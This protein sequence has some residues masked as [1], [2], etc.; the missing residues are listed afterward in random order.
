MSPL[1][2]VLA[3]ALAACVLLV[4]SPAGNFGFLNYDDNQYLQDVPEVAAGLSPSSIAWA[5]SHSHVGQWHPLTTLSWMMDVSLFGLDGGGGFHMHNVILHVAA[6]VLLFLAMRSL[7]GAVWRSA[8]VAALFGLHPLRV[9]SV[10]WIVERKDVLS[11]AFMMGTIWAY[12]AYAKRPFSWGRLSIVC[13]IFALGLLSKP[14]LVTLPVVFLLLDV[15]PLGRIQWNAAADGGA[16]KNFIQQALPLFKEKTPLFVLSLAAS[17]ITILGQ[18]AHFN[19]ITPL[20]VAQRLSYIP[21]SYVN[22]LIELVWPFNLSAHYP[23]SQDG[24]TLWAFVASLLFLIAATV[25]LFKLRKNYLCLLIGWLWFV[26]TLLPV[27]GIFYNGIQIRA[28]RYT[29]ISQIGLIIA[30][31]WMVWDLVGRNKN[32]KIA[33]SIAAPVL[34]MVL[35]FSSSRQVR[36]WESDLALWEHCVANTKDN[37]YAQSKLGKSLQDLKDY[38]GSEEHYRAALKLNPNGIEA[39]NNLASILSMKGEMQEALELQRRTVVVFPKW[40]LM[41]HNLGQHLAKNGDYAGAKNSYLRALELEP[42]SFATS[43]QLASML[44][45][46]FGDKASLEEAADILNRAITYQPLQAELYY[47]LGNI[48][49]RQAR[50]DD[51]IAS[52]RKTLEID[53]K[54]SGAANNLGALLVAKGLDDEAMELFT[55]AIQDNATNLDAYD[56]LAQTMIKK[57]KPEEAVN[58]LRSALKLAP[59]HPGCHIRLAW[60][61]ATSPVDSIRNGLEATQMANRAGELAGKNFPDVLDSLAAAYAE[62]GRFTEA[63]EAATKALEHP[64]MQNN[65]ERASQIRKHLEMYRSGRPFRDVAA[66]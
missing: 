38:A 64:A 15:W 14:M 48:R 39:L 27:I 66:P 61:L 51:A 10:A 43:Y 29:Y 16:M 57:G 40:H 63:Q 3:V 5:F 54:H 13:V 53:P 6:T 8:L 9:E 36:V 25:F 22:Y 50:A 60:V 49:Y 31:V 46:K 56:N 30:A 62:T 44:D 18:G 28:D 52:F 17:V 45:E 34:V 1:V 65:P 7:T 2:I 26:I 41:H 37:F 4:F 19:P 59:N 12:A 20:K 11:G 35:M 58:I 42:K 21:V 24:A 33:F 55:K 32:T 23:Y 47:L